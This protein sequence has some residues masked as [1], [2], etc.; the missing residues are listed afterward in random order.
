MEEAKYE[1]KTEGCKPIRAK[2]EC[3]YCKKEMEIVIAGMAILPS[4]SEVSGFNLTWIEHPAEKE[5]P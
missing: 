3:P 5:T 1:V 2:V 4:N